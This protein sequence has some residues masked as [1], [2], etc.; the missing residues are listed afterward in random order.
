MVSRFNNW[1]RMAA[2]AMGK[3]YE[4]N[5]QA[6]KDVKL[7]NFVYLVSNDEYS[8][9]NYS[10]FSFDIPFDFLH[11][12]VLMYSGHVI[13]TYTLKVLLHESFH[14]IGSL[15]GDPEEFEG[16]PDRTTLEHTSAPKNM[17]WGYDIMYNKGFFPSENALYGAP[18]MLTTDRIFFEWIEP[19]EVLAVNKQNIQG[20]KLRD[21]N[22]PLLGDSS[23]GIFITFTKQNPTREY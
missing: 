11:G 1:K 15:V 10:A 7:I 19:D 4:D 8:V 16:L 18:P 17:T 9:E 21:V 13:T 12:N 23:T 2:E 5:S 3:V 6:F 14:R 20:I 22:I